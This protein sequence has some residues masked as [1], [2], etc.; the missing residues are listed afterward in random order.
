[1]VR[2]Y[3]EIIAIGWQQA[4]GNTV[5]ISYTPKNNRWIDWIISNHKDRWENELNLSTC[6]E[7]AT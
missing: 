6:L 1:M 2:F 3:M 5:G 7:T 4:C